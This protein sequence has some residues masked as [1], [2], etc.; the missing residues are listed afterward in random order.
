MEL[1]NPTDPSNQSRASYL[2]RTT[3]PTAEE[4]GKGL[5]ER[6]MVFMKN[7][8]TVQNPGDSIV[9][10]TKQASQKVDF[11]GELA[12]IIG[13][14]CK[15]VSRSEALSYVFGYTVANDVSARDWQFE[16]GG[17]Q[18]CQGKSFDT[19][20]P[21]GPVLVTRDEIPNPNALKLKT[22]LN[23]TTMQDWTTEDMVFDVATLIEFLSGSKTLLPGTVILTGTPHGVGAARKPPVWLKAGDSVSIEI[24]GI[25]TLTNPVI[26]EA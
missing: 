7:T 5:P 24:Q 20:C 22:T 15:N 19:F 17:G 2:A 12:V 3:S 1:S 21:L 18:F 14:P 10:P 13:R 23:G 6:P 8:N 4:T 26:V 16:W 25:G 9:L 11:E